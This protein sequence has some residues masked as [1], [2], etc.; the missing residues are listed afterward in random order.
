[1]DRISAKSKNGLFDSRSFKSS[2]EILKLLLIFILCY[3]F[4]Q[5]FASESHCYFNNMYLM[6]MLSLKCLKYIIDWD[7]QLLSNELGVL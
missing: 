2:V 7:F 1:M 6:V 4:W 5:V 3:Y